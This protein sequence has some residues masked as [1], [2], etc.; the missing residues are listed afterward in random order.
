MGFLQKPDA[1]LEAEILA[2]ESAHRADVHRVERV[3]AVEPLAR[4]HREGRVAAP[5]EE[6]QH[7][8]VGDFLHEADAARAHDAT[9]VVE[10]DPLAD[11]H[12]FWFFDF[13]FL[14]A[15]LALAVFDGKFLQAALARLITNRAIERVVDQQKF[16]HPVAAFLDEWR[17]GAHAHSLAHFGRARN[18]RLRSP[19]DFG[20]S[21]R[22]QHG[23]AVGSHL[24]ASGLDETHAA[25]SR[26]AEFRMVA[27]VRNEF[28]A[29]HAGLDH[30]RALGEL[31]PF[32]VDLHIDHCHW[33]CRIA[34]V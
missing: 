3:I 8:V 25:I 21:I 26:R 31:L 9:L 34:H 13:L 14:K 33:S 19:G 32:P 4:I 22:S 29:L 5:V 7:I 1:H 10:H 24:R 11:V 30:A 18:F 2:R 28:S 15:R 12:P 27:I 6:A 16:H 23:L 17:R 20:P